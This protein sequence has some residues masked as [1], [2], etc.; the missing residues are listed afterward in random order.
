MGQFLYNLLIER[1][2]LFRMRTNFY[3]PGY[4]PVADILGSL[5]SIKKQ[6]PPINRSGA[7]RHPHC[8]GRYSDV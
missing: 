8:I 2:I 5:K 6:F 4:T 3:V 1:L 7:L